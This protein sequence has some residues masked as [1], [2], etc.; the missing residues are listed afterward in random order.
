MNIRNDLN[1][2]SSWGFDK[3]LVVILSNKKVSSQR[4]PSCLAVTGTFYA[5]VIGDSPPKNE[6]YNF[7]K[8]T[9]FYL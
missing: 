1:R 9:Q 3:T 2:I 7:V 4:I 6:I 8:S 5:R